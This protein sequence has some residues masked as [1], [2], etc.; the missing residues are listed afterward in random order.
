VR[1]PGS[2]PVIDQL[3]YAY[4]RFGQRSRAEEILDSITKRHLHEYVSPIAFAMVLLA[5]ETM[6]ALSIA[7]QEAYRT[8]TFRISGSHRSVLLG[9]EI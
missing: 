8:R 5:C 6:R 1:L 4:A 3:A 7:Q 9:T 2:L